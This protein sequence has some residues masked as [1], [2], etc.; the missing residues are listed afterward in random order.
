MKVKDAM[1]KG[2]D[3]VSPDTPVTE[4]AKLMREHD[5]G[6]IP[7]GENDRLIGISRRESALFLYDS[8]LRREQ[9]VELPS[10]LLNRGD[11]ATL[12]INPQRDIRGSSIKLIESLL[13]GRICVSTRDGARGFLNAGLDGLAIADGITGMAHE[14]SVLLD[15][16]EQRHRRERADPAR[17][18]AFTWDAV[19]QRH[20]A[21][22]RSLSPRCAPAS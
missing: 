10:G 20:L 21:L 7:I 4:L 5:I 16:R 6:A 1:H 11:R 14:I 19:A 3:W 8:G 9:R 17:L 22:Y 12:T 13:A 15:D 2:V 18:D